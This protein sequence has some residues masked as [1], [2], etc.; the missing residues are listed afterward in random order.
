[1]K[2]KFK[3]HFFITSFLFG[4]TIFSCAPTNK[5]P[6]PSYY[7]SFPKKLICFSNYE[8][9][10]ECESNATDCNIEECDDKGAQRTAGDIKKT[11]YKNLNKAKKIYNNFLWKNPGMEGWVKIKIHLT[12]EGKVIGAKIQSSEIKNIQFQNAIL[13]EIITWQFQKLKPGAKGNDT[14]TIPLRFYE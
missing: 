10:F 4:I 14:I 11:I 6:N 9:A 2:Y 13:R 12:P 8:E 3:I 1:M 5:K 7:E